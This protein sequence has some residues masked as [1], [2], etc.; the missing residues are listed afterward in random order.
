MDS[1]QA[2]ILARMRRL[3]HGKVHTAKDF[4]GLGSRAAIDQALSRLVR[5]RTIRRLARGLYYIPRMNPALDI[6]LAPDMDSVAQALAR[7]IG[8]R[9][10]P[11]G[12]VAANWLGLSAQV[13]AKPV[14]LTDG[15]TR[16]IRIGNTTFL[17]KHVSPKDLPL[18]SPTSAMVFQAL[19]YLGKEAMGEDT[20]ARLRRRLSPEERLKLLKDVRYATG[21]IARAVHQVCEGSGNRH[22]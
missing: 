21:W 14:Y 7:K 16:S 15:R 19:R 2:K 8:S 10:V 3:G 1:V 18:G 5:D 6:E 12:A 22:G 4:L 13:P 20:I 9:V 11:S 17:M